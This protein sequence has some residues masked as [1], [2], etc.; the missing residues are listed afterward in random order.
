MDKPKAHNLKKEPMLIYSYRKANKGIS[1]K[2]RMREK[3][4]DHLI[5]VR[6]F[7]AR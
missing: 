3:G 1:A 6:V 7:S 2:G 5:F 4:M